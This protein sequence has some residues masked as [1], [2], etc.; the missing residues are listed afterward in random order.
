MATAAVA[1][2]R[3]TTAA[4]PRRRIYQQP[5]GFLPPSV[6]LSIPEWSEEISP[7]ASR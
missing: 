7:S 3:E 5:I 6:N 2:S 4:L 1:E